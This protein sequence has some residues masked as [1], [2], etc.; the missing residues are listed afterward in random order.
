MH[1]KQELKFYF[2]H[3]TIIWIYMIQVGTDL[4]E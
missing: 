3:Y 4:L 1:G 2:G